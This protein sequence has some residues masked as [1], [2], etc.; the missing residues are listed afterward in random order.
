MTAQSI[1]SS[2]NRSANQGILGLA[3]LFLIAFVVVDTANHSLSRVERVT[4]EDRE[5]LK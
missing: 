3:V 1:L 4:Q 5:P 2:I